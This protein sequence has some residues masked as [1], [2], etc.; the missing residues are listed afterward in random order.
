SS[1]TG[2]WL[3]GDY[4]RVRKA[5]RIPA[6]NDGDTAQG[7]TTRTFVSM[8]DMALGSAFPDAP[9]AA[10]KLKLSRIQ[11]YTW[12]TRPGRQKKGFRDEC[13]KIGDDALKGS[14]GGHYVYS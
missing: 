13:G 14:H 10:D 2:L 11:H 6:V 4:M 9:F 3:A 12:L 7:A 5:R 8:L 1:N